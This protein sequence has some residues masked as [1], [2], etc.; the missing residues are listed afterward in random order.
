MVLKGQ[1]PGS[2]C[3]CTPCLSSVGA[4]LLGCRRVSPP[5]RRPSPVPFQASQPA[6]LCLVNPTLRAK[7]PEPRAVSAPARRRCSTPCSSAPGRVK[8]RGRGKKPAAHSGALSAPTQR[9]V[10]PPPMSQAS[11]PF[12]AG[13]AGAH[14]GRPSLLKGT[15]NSRR[16]IYVL[17]GRV[18]S[19][20]TGTSVYSLSQFGSPENKP[21]CLPSFLWS[22][23]LH[24]R[25]RAQ[26]RPGTVHIHM[27]MYS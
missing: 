27:I 24:R 17:L 13:A 4:R 26:I 18:K 11:L 10:F 16:Q 3:C 8:K 20:V 22:S 25:Q 2:R 15:G 6:R 7:F 14:W 23:R 9:G 12:A 5:S 21:I 1:L 19:V